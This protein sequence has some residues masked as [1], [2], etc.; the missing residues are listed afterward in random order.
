MILVASSSKPFQYTPKGTPRRHVILRAYEHEIESAYAAIEESSQ[1]D[2]PLPESFDLQSS[3][4][5]V[6]RA[7]E[8][9]MAVPLQADDDIFQHGCDRCGLFIVVSPQF[10]DFIS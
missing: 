10:A 2:I 3:V 7:I 8:K 6:R 1:P 9:V 4:A 5:F